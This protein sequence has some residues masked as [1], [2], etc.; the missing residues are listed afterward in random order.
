[1]NKKPNFAS[2]NCSP[3]H[4]LILEAMLKA[5]EGHAASYGADPWTIEAQRILE[6]VFQADILSYFVPSGTGSNVLALK[7]ACLR[8]ESVIC[9]EISHVHLQESGAFE[10]IVGCKLLSVPHFLGKVRAEDVLQKIQAE[11][12]SGKHATSPKVLSIAQPTEVG[13]VYSLNEL[14]ELS[15]LC[16]KEGLYLHIDGSRIYNAAVS[17]N[18]DLHE[19]TKSAGVDIL[20]LGGTK[21]G[22]VGAEALL[23]FNPKLRAGSDIMHKQTLQLLSKMRFLSAQFIAYFTNNLWHT[24]ATNANKQTA[25]LGTIIENSKLCSLSYPTKTNQIFFTTSKDVLPIIHQNIDCL[26]WDQEINQIRFIASWN[27]TDEEIEK[28][29]QIFKKVT[30]QF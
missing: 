5:N 17:L 30:E 6:N 13:T 14:R 11:K 25:K 26:L 4:P 8:Y 18:A 20:S 9:S 10:S 12:F 23:I 21:N 16:K 1:M 28:T 29:R 27:T 15:D 22:L 2:D 24:L 7:L 3:A 19:I